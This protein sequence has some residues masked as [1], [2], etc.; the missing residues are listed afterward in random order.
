MNM[1][2]LHQVLITL[3]AE[4]RLSSKHR[5]CVATLTREADKTVVIVADPNLEVA[6]DRAI[7][8]F[9]EARRKSPTA[10]SLVEY[11]TPSVDLANP[12]AKP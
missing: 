11:P 1:T 7:A 4:L 6:V 2:D 8:R 3:G 10:T 9:I 5:M 12:W